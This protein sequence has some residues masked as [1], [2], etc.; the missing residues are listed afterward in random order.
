MNTTAEILSQVKCECVQCDEI[1]DTHVLCIDCVSKMVKQDNEIH[2]SDYAQKK[3]RFINGNCIA[4]DFPN[5]KPTL[6]WVGAVL[7]LL[8]ELKLDNYN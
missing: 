8:K 2:L 6:E 7:D 5:N 3:L 4:T 1:K